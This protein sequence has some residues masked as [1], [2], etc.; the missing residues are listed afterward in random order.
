VCCDVAVGIALVL[1]LLDMNSGESSYFSEVRLRVAIQTW[2]S[3]KYNILIQFT[4]EPEVPLIDEFTQLIFSVQNLSSGQHIANLAGRVVVT[5]GQ[6][7]LKFEKIGIP[8]GDFSV[9]YLFL[10]MVPSGI[11]KNR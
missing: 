4:Y 8:D 10:M 2:I 5:S 7:L 3:Q 1:L 6:R 9:R 11:D